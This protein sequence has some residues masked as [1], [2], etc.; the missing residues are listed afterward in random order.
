MKT[1]FLSLGIRS[2]GALMRKVESQGPPKLPEPKS[3]FNTIPR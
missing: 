1:Y 3:A 2:N